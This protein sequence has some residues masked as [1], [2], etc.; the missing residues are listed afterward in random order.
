QDNGTGISVQGEM[1]NNL[2]FADD[3]DLVEE[4]SVALHNCVKLLNEARI[5]AGLRFNIGKTKTMIFGKEDIEQQIEVLNSRIENVKE[6]VYLGSVLT[7]DNDCSKDITARINN[8]KGVMAGFGEIW[9]SKEIKYNT[10]I[11]LVRAC[12]FSAA[13]YACEIWTLRKAD[14][15]SLLVF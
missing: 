4:S 11:D 10:K 3:I 2:R 1:I 6:F 15:A 7:W 9:G 14:R 8:A 13:L 5:E 12:V